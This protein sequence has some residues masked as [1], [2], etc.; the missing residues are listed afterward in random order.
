MVSRLADRGFMSG[1]WGYL[2][3]KSTVYSTGH[4]IDGTSDPALYQD[5]RI[6]MYTYL[7]SV[8]NGKY[9]VTLKFSENDPAIGAGQRVF[10]VWMQGAVQRS[11]FDIFV[12]AGNTRYKAKDL[13][14]NITVSDGL[15]AIDFQ[16][17][18]GVP[19]VQAIAV[20]GQ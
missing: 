14:F 20:V 11:D 1:S 9:K 7:F 6:G 2:G 19:V 8:P 4:V 17:K 12:A 13:N 16:R 10:D 5:G 3:P 18:V 15:L